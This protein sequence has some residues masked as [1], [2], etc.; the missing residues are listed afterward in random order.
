MRKQESKEKLQML[1]PLES[2]LLEMPRS[3]ARKI[4]FRLSRIRE[5]G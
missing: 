1:R 4:V 2:R 3:R 5:N